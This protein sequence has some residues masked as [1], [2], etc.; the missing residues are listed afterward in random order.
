MREAQKRKSPQ[1]YSVHAE[2]HLRAKFL[3]LSDQ[4]YGFMESAGAATGVSTFSGSSAWRMLSL[5]ERMPFP[6]LGRVQATSLVRTQKARL[7]EQ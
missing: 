7:R 3:L 1:M 6:T 2:S 4:T 5:K